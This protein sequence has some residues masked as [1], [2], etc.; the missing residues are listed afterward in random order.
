MVPRFRKLSFGA[1]RETNMPRLRPRQLL[2]IKVLGLAL[3]VSGAFP[4][5]LTS[6]EGP[7]VRYMTEGPRVAPIWVDLDAATR[8]DGAL[9][10][11]LFEE[12]ELERSGP[13]PGI[14]PTTGDCL[15]FIGEP[16][17]HRSPGKANSTLPEL[18]ESSLAIYTATVKEVHPGFF[19]GLAYSRLRVEVTE[20]FRTSGEFATSIL[21]VLYPTANFESTGRRFCTDTWSRYR[22]SP[23]DRLLLF[24][25][26]PA[27]DAQRSLVYPSS[28]EVAIE[29]QKGRFIYG[30]SLRKTEW[31]SA[32][33]FDDLVSYVG[34]AARRN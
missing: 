23:G 33:S 25:L 2:P 27:I 19:Q 28:E 4:L 26:Y 29:D 30:E 34:K 11:D 13:S 18:I 17:Y 32:A 9:R 21:D 7:V 3:V 12:G 14:D 20:R 8:S 22:P 15:S 10:Q 24:L 16:E 31:M 6:A 5:Q 1:F